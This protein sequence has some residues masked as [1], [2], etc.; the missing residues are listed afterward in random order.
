KMPLGMGNVISN[1]FY[2]AFSSSGGDDIIITLEGCKSYSRQLLKDFLQEIKDQ[3]IVLASRYKS[4]GSYVNFPLF[5]KVFSKALNFLLRIKFPLPGV[6]DYT[7]FLRAYRM[8]VV[9]E[10]FK[11]FG[12]F[13]FIQSRGFVSNVELLIKLSLFTKRIKEVPFVYDLKKNGLR[14]RIKTLQTANEYFVLASYLKRIFKKVSRLNK[15][16]N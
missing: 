10:A 12:C 8:S 11:Y 4:P 2:E 1:G 6:S 14:Y 7:I 16:E 15:E 3:D 9:K 5:R 13:G